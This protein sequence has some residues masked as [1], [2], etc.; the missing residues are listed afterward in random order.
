MIVESKNFVSACYLK[1]DVMTYGQGRRIMFTQ[2]FYL[3]DTNNWRVI[4][5]ICVLQKAIE[6][7]VSKYR[8]CLDES[9]KYRVDLILSIE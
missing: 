9:H 3:C 5:R 2:V 6:C 8:V 4:N 1:V 7:N